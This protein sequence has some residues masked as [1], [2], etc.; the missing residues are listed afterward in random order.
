MGDAPSKAGLRRYQAMLAGQPKNNVDITGGNIANVTITDANLVNVDGITFDTPLAIAS[1]GTS[2]ATASAARTALGLA[3]G[4]NVQAYNANLTSWAALTPPSGSIVGTTDSQALTNKTYN[5]LTL[6]ATNGTLT[7]PNSSSLILSGA[8]S[9]T[10]TTSGATNVTF[11][12]S[13]TLLT[14]TVTTLS[15]LSSVG[16]ITTGTW[17]AGVIAGQYGGT[18]VANTGKTITLGG[19]FT[20]SGAFATT[21][22]ATNTTTLT[23]P[24][25]GTLA[26]LAGSETLTNKTFNASNNTVS[27]I[28]LATMVTGNLPVTNLN[29]GTSA[30]SST[31]WRGDGT[32]AAAGV[33]KFTSTDQ[34][35]TNGGTLTIAHGL[36]AVPFGFSIYYVCQTAEQGYSIGDVVQCFSGDTNGNRG[37]MVTVDAT[38][39]VVIMGSSGQQMLNKSTGTSVSMTNANWKIRFKAWI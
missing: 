36:G 8:N 4:T 25:T 26:T 18:G 32:W 20:T 19:N 21:L 33:T 34:T 29:S 17:N 16:T 7:L 35:I 10:L 31:F 11:P 9:L 12:T 5:G 15:S 27:N 1:G 2:A 39:L 14:N 38:N 22:T 3:I 6:T 37:I 30:S 23:L 28:S 13:G 24:V